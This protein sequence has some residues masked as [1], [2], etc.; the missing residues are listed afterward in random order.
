MAGVTQRTVV[1]LRRDVDEKLG[2]LPL[3]YFDNHP[4]GDLLSRVTNDIDNV[5]QSLQQTM[6]QLL[7]SVLTVIG[8]L[9]IM[10][11]ISPVLA[12]VA[13]VT[14]PLSTLITI[15]IAK[16]SQPQFVRQWSTTGKLNAHVEEAYT[17]HEL[18]KV[19]G[20]TDE[21]AAEFRRL[22]EG[23]YA[24]SFKAQFISGLIMPAMMFV[25]NLNY[26]AIAV[27]GG[28]RVA[29]GAI[30]LGDVQPFNIEG[31]GNSVKPRAGMR[32]RPLEMSP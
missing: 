13:L 11:Y 27:I 15:T 20:R 19:F 8:V 3:R 26:V 10:I 32:Q 31:C 21:T 29:S 17:G 7:T 28:L 22:N 9:A 5:A 2:R 6:S 30:S 16:R 23:L 25:A 24:S 14:V 18:V 1:K 12:V 4:R